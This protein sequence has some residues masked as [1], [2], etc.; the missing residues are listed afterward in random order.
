MSA[1]YLYY[2]SANTERLHNII[3]DRY[4]TE[5]YAYEVVVLALTRIPRPFLY[6]RY[7]RQSH[8]LPIFARLGNCRFASAMAKLG[9]KNSAHRLQA[10]AFTTTDLIDLFLRI[11]H[12]L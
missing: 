8:F 2:L 7:K 11:K 3:G 1:C 5:Q 10:D 12:C 9:P 4:L 6:F